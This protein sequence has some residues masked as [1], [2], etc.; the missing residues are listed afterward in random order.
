MRQKSNTIEHENEFLLSFTEEFYFN[1]KF[2]NWVIGRIEVEII[3]EIY[4]IDEIRFQAPNSKA[5][6]K[7]REK[8][9][10]VWVDKDILEK[11][12]KAVKKKFF[13]DV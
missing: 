9:D 1:P 3:N 4:A 6:V 13:V 11:V 2:A 8:F 5:W 10:G 7:F 12:K